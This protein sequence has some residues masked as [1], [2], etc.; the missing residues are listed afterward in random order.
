MLFFFMGTSFPMDKCS[1]CKGTGKR[2][3]DFCNGCGYMGECAKCGG[4]G[5]LDQ[6]CFN[7]DGSGYVVTQI[8][9]NS[10]RSA[11]TICN[12][13]GIRPMREKCQRCLGTG[14]DTKCM[15]CLGTGI[16][17]CRFCSGS[18]NNLDQKDT[19]GLIKSQTIISNISSDMY[20]FS[21]LQD[22][23]RIPMIV[24]QI[25]LDECT[26]LS[27]IANDTIKPKSVSIIF[28][29]EDSLRDDV[30]AIVNPYSSDISFYQVIK[31]LFFNVVKKHKAIG[32]VELSWDNFERF[33]KINPMRIVTKHRTIDLNEVA[34]EKISSF[35]R[36]LVDRHE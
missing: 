4:L 19:L 28:A 32:V 13:R 31:S 20:R 33:I 2:Q 21:T 7:C 25:D 15:T 36:Y 26:S 18:G 34:L 10:Q 27:F 29:S 3:C 8:G 6:M 23:I 35:H 17:K 1:S 30:V 9:G 22:S 5:R 24:R 14:H 11:C 12:G 16:I